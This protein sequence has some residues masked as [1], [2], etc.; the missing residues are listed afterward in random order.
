[1]FHRN[2]IID[3]WLTGY[4]G[5][6]GIFIYVIFAGPLFVVEEILIAQETYVDI[7]K[8][9]TIEQ[10]WVDS[11]EEQKNFQELTENQKN[12][13]KE[14][15]SSVYRRS[16]ERMMIMAREASVQLTYQNALLMYQFFYPPLRELDFT[17][18]QI[19][20]ISPSVRWIAGLVFQIISIV[21]SAKSTF[22]PINDYATLSAFKN[23]KMVGLANYILQ[24]VQV[25][26]HLVFASGV[27][28]LLKV[29]K[30]IL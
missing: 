8:V 11:N 29:N 16:D 24:M 7:Q 17:N 6:F 1:M 18:N 14:Y 20:S 19:S 25:I 27:V 9:K 10:V 12:T 2:K 4:F 30:Y 22:S 13:L 28:Y 21:L 23:G 3:K 26:L 15:Y 5:V